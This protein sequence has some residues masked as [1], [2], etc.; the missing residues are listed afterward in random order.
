MKSPIQCWVSQ[1][2]GATH[3]LEDPVR[4]GLRGSFIN[5]LLGIGPNL[6]VGSVFD[7]GAAR[8]ITSDG[9]FSPKKGVIAADEP[10]I[11]PGVP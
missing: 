1:S 2:N 11:Q 10:E 3:D 5:F 6:A 9:E 8:R 7:P 4:S